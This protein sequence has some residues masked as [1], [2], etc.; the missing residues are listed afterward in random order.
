VASGSDAGVPIGPGTSQTNFG[1]IG[2][3]T[4]GAVAAVMVGAMAAYL[5]ARRRSRR[6]SDV[7][8]CK[9]ETSRVNTATSSPVPLGPSAVWQSATRRTTP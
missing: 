9:P 3:V 2:G 4:A 1:L 8:G 6:R 7:H 5:L